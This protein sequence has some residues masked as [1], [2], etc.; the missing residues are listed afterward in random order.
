MKKK[1]ELLVKI[2]TAIF[3]VGLL[4]IMPIKESAILLFYWLLIIFM[5]I[6][7]WLHIEAKKKENYQH[8]FI[9]IALSIVFLILSLL[10]LVGYILNSPVFQGDWA[11]IF[12]GHSV[13]AA[14]IFGFYAIFMLEKSFREGIKRRIK[15]K[16][17]TMP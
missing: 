6:N 17:K 5:I 4:W 12:G 9:S 3:M 13:A 16:P 1:K 2:L 14:L 7:F 15:N 10:S 11:K 8:F